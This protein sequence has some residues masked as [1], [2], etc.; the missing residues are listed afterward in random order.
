[1]RAQSCATARHVEAEIRQL[2]ATE[3]RT[4]VVS[5]K[6]FQQGTGFSRGWRD[7]G[8]NARPVQSALFRA[9]MDR[10]RDLQYR[11]AEP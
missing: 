3:T 1:M 6:L 5:N 7:G 4:T 10:V 11:D 2:L 8:E 9:A